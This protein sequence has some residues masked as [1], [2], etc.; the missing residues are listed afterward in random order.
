MRKRIVVLG[1][2][3]DGFVVAEAVKHLCAAGA[4]VELVGFL[5]DTEP[6]GTTLHGVP[7]L[8]RLDDW[9]DADPDMLFIPAIQ[10][11]KDMAR[12]VRRIAS[13]GIPAERWTTVIHPSAVVS[14]DVPVGMGAFIASN[15]TVQPASRVGNFASL[16]AGAMMGHECTVE[17]HAYVGANAVMCGRSRLALAA[18]LGPGSVLLENKVM[19]PFSVCGIASAVTKDVREYQIV[20]GHPARRVGIVERLAD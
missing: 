6:R 11:A 18:H 4:P 14:S 9:R 2:R 12:R 20:F 13:L 5:N 1:G 16:R 3:G 15:A 8:A 17:D 7:V 19:G 10:K